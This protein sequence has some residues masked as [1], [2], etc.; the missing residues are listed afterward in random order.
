MKQKGISTY[1]RE[2]D[3]LTHENWNRSYYR[4]SDQ[5]NFGLSPSARAGLWIT[6]WVFFAIFIAGLIS[7][8]FYIYCSQEVEA[9]PVSDNEETPKTEAERVEKEK[10]KDQEIKLLKTTTLGMR[11]KGRIQKMYNKQ[12]KRYY[13]KRFKPDPNQGSNKKLKKRVIKRRSVRTKI[14]RT[15]RNEWQ[16]ESLDFSPSES[17]SE[18]EDIDE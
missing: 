11:L 4:F 3:E 13:K 17:Y 8:F 5:S 12:L 15:Q 18:Y 14:E 10:E 1:K 2:L 9:D 7:V 6:L 16:I